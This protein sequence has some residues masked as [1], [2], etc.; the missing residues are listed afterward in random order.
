[1]T[2]GGPIE[3]EQ[4]R[5]QYRLKMNDLSA[6]MLSQLFDF[7]PAVNS[8][9]KRFLWAGLLNSTLCNTFHFLSSLIAFYRVM[10]VA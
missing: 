7:I 1:M 9:P 3:V 2:N 10:T 8:L 6:T 5:L 4:E